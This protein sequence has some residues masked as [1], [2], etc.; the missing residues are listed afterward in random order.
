MG[1]VRSDVKNGLVPS[2]CGPAT[3]PPRT[4]PSVTRKTRECRRWEG[5]DSSHWAQHSRFAAGKTKAERKEESCSESLSRP[6][7]GSPFPV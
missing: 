6:G 7:E 2:P 4:K 1:R 3:W 5:S